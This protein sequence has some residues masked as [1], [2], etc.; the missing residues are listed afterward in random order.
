MTNF[1]F[2]GTYSEFITDNGT[3]YRNFLIRNPILFKPL[4]PQPLF[5]S[6]SSAPS[7]PAGPSMSSLP[8]YEVIHSSRPN[9]EVSSHHAMNGMDNVN[10]LRDAAVITGGLTINPNTFM[11]RVSSNSTWT[12]K[13]L[14]LLLLAV[15][16]IITSEIP[17]EIEDQPIDQSILHNDDL[18]SE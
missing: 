6:V 2:N 8:S 16:G 13:D 12:N 5:S 7:T 4:I 11:Q 10:R 3:N 15:N 18:V 9:R 17:D 1:F 14:M